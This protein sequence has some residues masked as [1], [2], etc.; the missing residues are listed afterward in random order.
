MSLSNQ[1][2]SMPYYHIFLQQ[3]WT[4]YFFLND[5]FHVYTDIHSFILKLFL[6]DIVNNVDTKLLYICMVKSL[7]SILGDIYTQKWIWVI[8][9]SMNLNHSMN[10]KLSHMAFYVQFCDEP[11]QHVILQH[12]HIFYIWIWHRHLKMKQ[13]A[14]CLSPLAKT[15][16]STIAE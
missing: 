13:H 4:V 10:L 14:F 11:P 5:E 8:W 12:L 15:C 2:L 6:W 3:A 1:R 16:F 7:P 9:H